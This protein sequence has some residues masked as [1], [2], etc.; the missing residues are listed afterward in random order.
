MAPTFAQPRSTQPRLW[1]SLALASA[2][3][4][5]ATM[6][7][8]AQN[9]AVPL[10]Q[11]PAHDA[12]LWLAQAEGGEGGE[13]GAVASATPDVA[14][15]ARLAIVEGH[16]RAALDLYRKGLVDEAVGL[17]YHPEAEMMDDVRADLAA[18]AAADI[19]PAM[20][21]FSATLE[22][23]AP[24]PEVEAALA[25]VQS[26]IAAAMAPK[27][28]DLR[29]RFDTLTALLRAAASEYASSTEGGSVGDVMAYHESHAFIATARSLAAE[30]ALVPAAKD[31]ADRALAAMAEADG[32]FGDMSLATYL[33]SDPAI[34]LAVA[35]RV[36]LIASSVR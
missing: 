8:L 30:L 2:T 28:G 26:A 24:V 3:V 21:A 34:L 33:V 12:T 25:A 7:A 10:A 14:Y 35:A 20:T 31:A 5:L 13:A 15:L 18:H 22:A 19:T 27:A 17:S 16:L 23:A 32:A 6:P 1:R 9:K 4:T 29:V 36:E 11:I